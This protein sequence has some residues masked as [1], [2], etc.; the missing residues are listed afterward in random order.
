MTRWPM[1]A[2]FSLTPAPSAATMPHGSWPA[3]TGSGLTG[4]P[5]TEA[6]PL[7]RRYWWRSLPHM[8]EAFISTTTSPGPG[9]GSE[10]CRSSTALSPGN[11]IP[12]MMVPARWCLMPP[13]YDAA[14]W[15]NRGRR[16][17][18][19]AADG[20]APS[21][22]GRLLVGGRMRRPADAQLPLRVGLAQP[23]RRGLAVETVEIGVQ[24][25]LWPGLQPVDRLEPL[26][27]IG[28][29]RGLR[30]LVVAQRRLQP[31]DLGVVFAVQVARA[32]RHR[33]T[34]RPVQ[35]PAPLIFERDM[36]RAGRIVIAP[37]GGDTIDLLAQRGLDL[38]AG[39]RGE[40]EQQRQ[41]QRE[42]FPMRHGLPRLGGALVGG[43]ASAVAA[44][45]RRRSPR[46]ARRA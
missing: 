13:L 39:R 31:A 15:W 5:P 32:F 16:V 9:A 4:S 37:G 41:Q 25:R 42:R 34:R 26:G 22:V 19:S 11:T 6:P 18:R 28:A 1:R 29:Q 45:P 44:R 7:G 17:S 40:D 14:A 10:N 38:R 43:R 20:A 30:F 8:P 27:V 33:R 35:E 21:S 36:L 24:R 46:S 3:M 23:D 12:R 2:C